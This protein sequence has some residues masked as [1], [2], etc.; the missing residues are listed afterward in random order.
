MNRERHNSPAGKGRTLSNQYTEL[1]EL[2]ASYNIFAS[3]K[4]QNCSRSY[5]APSFCHIRTM[6]RLFDLV[7]SVSQNLTEASRDA[8]TDKITAAGTVSLLLTRRD[9]TDCLL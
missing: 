2:Y 1:L 6:T 3:R 9:P 5:L 8:V 4:L 7:G